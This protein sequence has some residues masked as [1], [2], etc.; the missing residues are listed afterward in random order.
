MSITYC[1]CVIVA[2]CIQPA[3]R[4]RRIVMCLAHAQQ[5]LPTLYH[6]RHDLRK[7]VTE[8]KMCVL[9]YLQLL[10]SETFLILRATE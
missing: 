7:N 1:E 10:L 5:S 9:I 8:H 2:L 6:K 4:M 3:M